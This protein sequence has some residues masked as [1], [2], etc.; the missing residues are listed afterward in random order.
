ME[1]IQGYEDMKSL[2]AE[3]GFMP[4]FSNDIEGFSIEDHT[5]D[6]LW[7]ADD[8]EDPWEWKGPVVREGQ[9]VYGKFFHG[10][11]G[12]ISKELFAEFANYRRRSLTLSAMEKT[13]YDTV[14]MNESLLTKEIR[15]LCGY[16]R[17]R[18]EHSSPIES[19]VERMV[20]VRKTKA[21]D[22]REGFDTVMTR[23]QMST[24]V[25]IADF[26][27]NVDK[28]GNAYGWGLARYSTPEVL[29]GRELL[30]ACA[31]HSAEESRT[32]LFEHLSKVLPHA[33]ERQI[34]YFV[35]L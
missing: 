27:Y 22:A 4:F 29:Y 10:K 25:V 28:R 18:K 6:D 19:V 34:T 32:K 2:I 8:R 35:D 5:P 17:R 33:S 16:H 7:F 20:K 12:F 23:L 15:A 1:L 9:F 14:V 13:V 3:Y 31:A 26:E 21:P 11:M 30:D 24:W